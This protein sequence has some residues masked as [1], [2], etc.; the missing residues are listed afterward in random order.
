M[1]RTP[2]KRTS[3]PA[4]RGR[5]VPCQTCGEE[6]YV[7][8][9]DIGRKFCSRTCMGFNCRVERTCSICGTAFFSRPRQ[10][11][12]NKTC[13]PACANEAKRRSKTGARNPSY[14]N[15]AAANRERWTSQAEPECRLCGSRKR[16]QLH[17]VVY[18]QHVRS[19]KGDSWEPANSFTICWRCHN[20]HHRSIDKRISFDSLRP[21]S[22]E[23]AR[24]LLGD[25]APYYFIRYYDVDNPAEFV[26]GWYPTTEERG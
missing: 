9:G 12:L 17:H 5:Y 26:A 10:G 8:P 19:R 21:E 16:L 25:A 18:E 14:K 11:R 6:F 2:L 15:G 3:G 20:T 23:F 4:R 13:G 7:R 22:V 24:A 1:K